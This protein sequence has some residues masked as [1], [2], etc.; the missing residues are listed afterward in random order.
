MG[1][2]VSFAA[3][4]F[5]PTV[6]SPAKSLI[7]LS[8]QPIAE[9]ATPSTP[10]TVQQIAT[11]AAAI[12]RAPLPDVSDPVL[13]ATASVNLQTLANHHPTTPFTGNDLEALLLNRKTG[14]EPVQQLLAVWGETPA[15]PPGVRPCEQVKRYQL[16]CLSGNGDWDELRRY[17]RP[18]MLTLQLPKHNTRHDV[19]LRT[20]EDDMATLQVTGSTVPISLDRLDELWTGDY[21][22]LW[23]IQTS[24]DFIAPGFIG[25]PVAWLR[26]RLALAE[27]QDLTAQ[28]LS[29]IFDAA[30]RE[31]V[32]AFQ[33]T[34]ALQADGIVGRRTMALLN[35]LAPTPD[36]P[37]LSPPAPE[38]ID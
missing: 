24:L 22:M 37:L 9:T 11:P 18:V 29:K 13:A 34:N 25:E 36:T 14:A 16:R 12:P 26:Q 10:P 33:R 17:N 1:G 23:R 7:P 31:R 35:N 3:N 21:F 2:L 38:R 5:S 27:G 6:T 28:S 30:L 8:I 15:I 32:Q 19:L 20:L 4:P